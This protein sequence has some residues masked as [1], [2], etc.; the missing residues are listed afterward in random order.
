MNYCKRFSF[1]KLDYIHPIK[2][3]FLLRGC[4]TPCFGENIL[5]FNIFFIS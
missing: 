3:K 1:L 4:H 2:I 5:L